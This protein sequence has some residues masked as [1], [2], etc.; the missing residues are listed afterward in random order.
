MHTDAARRDVRRLSPRR[1]V[2]GNENEEPIVQ[3]SRKSDATREYTEYFLTTDAV[4]KKKIWNSSCS[5]A[6][7]RKRDSSVDE[8][9]DANGR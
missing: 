4:I 5:F 3:M 6:R 9:G 7:N 1:S 8:F 2:Q